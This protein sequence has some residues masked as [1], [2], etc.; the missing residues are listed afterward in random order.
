MSAQLAEL[1]PRLQWAV[2][3]GAISVAEAWTFQDLISVLPETSAVEA[4]ECLQSM[5]GRMWLLE[6][7]PGN[8]L[9]A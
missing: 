1:E 4:P 6:S 5:L 2:S 7:E 8:S 9:P 3:Q